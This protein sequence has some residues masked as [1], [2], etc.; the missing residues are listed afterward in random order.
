MLY[1]LDA[2]VLITAHHHYYPVDRVPEYWEWLTFMG[3]Q[4]KVKL[5]FEI[6]DE[7]KE[8]PADAEKDLLF[9]WLQLKAT[10]DSLLLSDEVD[11]T[12]VQKVIS[13]GYASDLTDDQVEYI[14]RDPFLIAHA[15]AAN[16][17]C[18]VT[19]ENSEPKK[20]RQNRKIPDVCKT[21]KQPCCGPFA[22]NK[23]LGFRT[24]WKKDYGL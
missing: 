10:K 22:F 18:V 7:I 14:G 16:E 11:P 1:L 17:R 21:F 4:G 23:A 2:S 19:V 24:S 13:E 8:G 20:Q 15:M 12:L 5:P 9:A 3:Q 6:F